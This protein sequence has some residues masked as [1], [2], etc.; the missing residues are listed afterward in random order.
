V[1]NITMTNSTQIPRVRLASP[2][3]ADRSLI[4]ADRFQSVD[5]RGGADVPVGLDDSKPLALDVDSFRSGRPP[6]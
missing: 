6:V 3:V 4:A 5:V 1:K 2:M